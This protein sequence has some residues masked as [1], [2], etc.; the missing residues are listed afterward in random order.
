MTV[1]IEMTPE[2]EAV[3]R[4]E[5]GDLNRAAREALV[6]ESYRQ[7]KLSLGQCSGLLGLSVPETEAFFRGRGVGLGLT[8]ENVHDD[9]VR[10][11][12]ILR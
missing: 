3:L 11:K 7:A 9:M 4:A 10:L 5:W 8:L 1:V 6:I 12:G 2:A